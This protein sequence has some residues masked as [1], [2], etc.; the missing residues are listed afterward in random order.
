MDKK[1]LFVG[2][3][4]DLKGGKSSK[5]VDIFSKN[6]PNSTLYNGGNYNDLEKIIKSVA[7]Y[8]IVF[9]W[10]DVDNKLPKI[11]NIKDINY[12]IMLVSSKRNDNNM[13]S[14][15]QLLQK[16]LNMK[17]NLTV[18]F[19]KNKDGF[20]MRVFDPLGNVWYEG[21]NIQ[22][23]SYYILERLDSIK[24]TTRLSTTKSQ[25]S[26]NITNN[27]EFFKIVREYATRFAVTIFPDNTRRFLGNASFRCLKGFPSYR[28]NNYIYVSRRNVNKEFVD[29]SDFVMAYED[30]D[31]IYY[32]GD[33]KPSVDTPVQV[34]LYRKLPN[35]NYMI[36][37]HCYIKNAPYTEH[38]L[39][40]GA[41][42]E[43][44][45]IDKL[46]K[47]YYDGDYNR[48]FYVFN[49]LGHG[50]IMMSSDPKKLENIELI[51]REIM[52]YKTLKKTK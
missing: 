15:E 44:L 28:N 39:P 52:E 33:N 18:E 36:H 13:Y 50:C 16:S 25:N 2:G 22:D 30:N 10:A 31:K 42:E 32:C 47:E 3:T 38:K 12:K 48:S 21:Y 37:S 23:C 9:W 1:I 5:I 29:K 20:K 14:D 46:I 11:R 27:E 7:D 45:E 40:C 51:R 49:L 35:I 43:V 17:A 4:W 41:L 8:D 6:I 26:Y 34:K 19:S 24:D